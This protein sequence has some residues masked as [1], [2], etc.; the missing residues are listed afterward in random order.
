MSGRIYNHGNT[1]CEYS[2]YPTD[3]PIGKIKSD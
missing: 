1:K 3:L 2:R